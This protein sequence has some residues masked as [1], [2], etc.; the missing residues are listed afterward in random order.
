MHG[1]NRESLRSLGEASKGYK[2][3]S[4]RA[5]AKGTVR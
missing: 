1:R 4:E 2:C 3:E 5:G